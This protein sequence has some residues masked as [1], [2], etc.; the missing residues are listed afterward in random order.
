MSEYERSTT[1]RA[2]A[3]AVLAFASDVRNLPKYL[4]TTHHAEPQGAERVAVAG[5]AKGHRY[6]ADGYL[7]ADRERQRLEWGS[8]EG[9]YSGWLQVE[10]AGEGASRVTVHLSMRA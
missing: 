8:D 5:E 1:I 9:H 7:R 4:P 3:E 10:P 6:Q 2:P